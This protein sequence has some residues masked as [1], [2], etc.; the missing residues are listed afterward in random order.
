MNNIKIKAIFC[1]F[2][3]LTLLLTACEPELKKPTNYILWI[4]IALVVIVLLVFNKQIR[5]ILK[6]IPVV[7]KVVP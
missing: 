3:V 6:K 7:G 4:G 1:I 5:M 2:I